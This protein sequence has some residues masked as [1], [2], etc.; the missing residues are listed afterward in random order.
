MWSAVVS[1]LGGIAACSQARMRRQAPISFSS[2]MS[3]FVVITGLSG[4]GRSLAADAI[5]DLGWFVIDNLPPQLAAEGHELVQGPRVAGAADRPRGRHRR[6]PGRGA[7]DA[8]LALVGRR[9]VRIVFL[10]AATDTLV[11][12]YESTRAAIPSRAAEPRSTWWRRSSVSASC[13]TPSGPRPTWWST[14]ASSTCTSCA[15]GCR[16]C[17]PPRRPGRHADDRPVVRLQARAAAGR[18]HGDRLS[19]PAQ[20]ALGRRAPPAHGP[21]PARCATTSSSSQPPRSSWKTSRP[22][23]CSCCRRTWPRARRT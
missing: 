9:P 2:G 10:D 7:A 18:R 22:C 17:S 19:V 14:P 16:A 12:R 13:W 1:V 4:A 3:D 5:E 20:P 6:L 23:W 8:G 15:S 21:R 11:R